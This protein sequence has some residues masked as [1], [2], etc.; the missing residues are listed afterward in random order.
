[1]K[2]TATLSGGSAPTG[3]ITFS[4][5][6]PSESQNCT[7]T[8][9]YTYTVT[10][11]GNG[12]YT[13]PNGFTPVKAGTYWWTA[14]YGG[15]NANNSVASGCGAESVTVTPPLASPALTTVPG[16]AGVGQQRR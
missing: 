14:S 10:L 13:T 6:G 3:T 1:M 11:N 7:T 8:A 9:V 2:D 4:L 5:Y 16:Q 15:D 12:T